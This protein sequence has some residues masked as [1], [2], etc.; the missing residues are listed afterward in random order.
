VKK[1]LE[2]EEQKLSKGAGV[3]SD[4]LQ[5]KTALNSSFATYE[6]ANGVLINAAN[7]FLAAF[8]DA[9]KNSV[10]FVTNP[11]GVR[12][13]NDVRVDVNRVI[14]PKLPDVS[15]PNALE[16]AI[17]RA[18]ENNLTL[19]QSRM[20]LTATREKMRSDEAKLYGPSINF[21]Y[22][23]SDKFDA[24]AIRG[25]KTEN[26]SKF[27]LTFPLFAGFKHKETS[28]GSKANYLAQS[29]RYTD[30]EIGIE[31]LVRDSWQNVLTQQANA[32]FLLKQAESAKSFLEIARK[33][34]PLGKRSLL[35]I[36]NGELA[37]INA[38]SAA[39]SAAVDAVLAK[40][41]LLVAMGK[42]DLVTVL[43]EDARPKQ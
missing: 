32:G 19:K 39:E 34:R 40:Y 9:G 37:Y 41:A 8:R 28:A 6:R 18:K 27:E 4:V 12:G 23:Y 29:E 10:K 35:D 17:Q 13:A 5:A 22:K 31:N 43:G 14:K 2:L 20:A 1:Q 16:E 33:E 7:G 42:L 21:I 25:F 30:E 26:L 11:S 36:L 24:A 38:S 15:L 3:V